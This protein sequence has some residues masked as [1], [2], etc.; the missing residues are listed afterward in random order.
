MTGFAENVTVSNCLLQSR[1]AGIRVGYGSVPIRN[2]VFENIVIY[3]SNRGIGVFARDD[4]E[5]RHIQFNNIFIQTRIHTG[6]WWGNGEPLHVSAIPQ[7]RNVPAGKISDIS[8]RNITAQSETGMVFFAYEQGLVEDIH[9]QN[10]NL[11]ISPGKNTAGYGGNIDLRP[12]FDPEY[13]IF[14]KDLPGLLIKN[15]HHAEIE[16]FDLSWD[17]DVPEYHNHGIGIEG[18]E[19]VL[20]T[21]FSGREP[22]QDPANAAISIIESSHTLIRDSYAKPGTG[23]FVLMKNNKGNN[24]LDNNLTDNA[25]IKLMQR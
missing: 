22:H 17:G 4:A 11:T 16:N 2:C 3:N 5:I 1:S 10:I 18:S 13:A 19:H 24:R 8:F 7:D 9:F 6:H 25:K 14:E 12:V 20:I 15:I 21:E 23:I